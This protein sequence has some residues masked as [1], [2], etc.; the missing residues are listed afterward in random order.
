MSSGGPV[1]LSVLLA[2][3]DDRVVHSRVAAVRDD[4]LH[5]KEKSRVFQMSLIKLA[6]S[7]DMIAVLR[8]HPS[9]VCPSRRAF[10]ENGPSNAR[11]FVILAVFL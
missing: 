3:L 8:G 7:E 6:S 9:R 11:V 2:I 4:T 1:K 5:L 10:V